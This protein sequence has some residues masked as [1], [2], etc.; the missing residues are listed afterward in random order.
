M[1]AVRNARKPRVE[2]DR[3]RSVRSLRID[4]THASSQSAGSENELFELVDKSSAT[5]ER[6][7]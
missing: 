6:Q 1:A 5:N 2:V 4:G 3:Q 7:F